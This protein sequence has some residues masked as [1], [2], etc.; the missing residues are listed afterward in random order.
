LFVIGSSG[1]L[2]TAPVAD[3]G[4]KRIAL[5]FDDGPRLVYTQ[6]LIDILDEANVHATFFVVGKQAEKFPDLVR[7]LANHGHE[8]ANHSWSH[9]SCRTINEEELKAELDKTRAYLT[10]L[11]GHDTPLFRAP[12][13]T[14][15]YLMNDIVIPPHYEMVMWTVHSLDHER[16]PASVIRR[17]VL[18]GARD[19]A[20]VIFHTGVRQTL[21]ALP[22]IIS[23]LRSEGYTF[24]TVSEM[25][26]RVPA[27]R[28][29][30]RLV[31]S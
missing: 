27:S 20:V 10:Q 11:T 17:R 8:I 15:E 28:A 5:T 16:P 21:D 6:A 14:Y 30:T 23:T 19:G 18:A 31:S 4:L 26:G 25:L 3:S 1:L 24:V 9:P 22:G 29:F 13:G 12:G 7:G 2:N